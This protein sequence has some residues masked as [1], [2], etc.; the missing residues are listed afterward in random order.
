MQDL[1]RSKITPQLRKKLATL[2]PALITEHGKDIQHDK[3]QNPSAGFKPTQVY[4]SSS[5]NK[6]S[7]NKASSTASSASKGSSVNVTTVTDN[8]EFRTSAEELYITFTD[9]QRIAAFT[10]APPKVFEGANVGSKFELFGGNVSGEY[11]KLDKPKHITQKWRLKQWPEGHYSTLAITFD[12]N[13][14]DA[15]TTMRVEWKGVP[16]GQE[17][18][19]KKN[20]SEYYVRSIKY[21]I[22]PLSL[23]IRDST[24]VSRQPQDSS[25]NLDSSVGQHLASARFYESSVAAETESLETSCWT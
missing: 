21:V 16:I 12:Q 19:T 23:W 25:T 20:W 24:R 14:V 7:E 11:T 22:F 17:E 2:G 15:V 1:V 6:T 18:V 8:E 13:D 10:R 9:P 4:S 5:I 3:N